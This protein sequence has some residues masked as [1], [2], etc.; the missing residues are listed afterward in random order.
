M[1]S[2]LDRDIE[3]ARALLDVHPRAAPIT[4]L[5]GLPRDVDGAIV[6]VTSHAHVDLTVAL[7]ERGIPVLLEKPL[8]TDD[9]GLDALLE[10][11]QHTGVSLWPAMI[12]RFNPAF[13]AALEDLD[14]VMF[15][16]A[17]RL[18]PYSARALDIDVVLDLMIHDLDLILSL[19]DGEVTDLRAVG[20]PVLTERPDMAHAR[21]EFS[22]GAVAVLA[23]SRVSLAPTR[24]LRLFG[25]R[26]YH[27]VDLL[28]RRVHRCRR[29]PGTESAIEA[30]GLPV[31]EANALREQQGAF[32]THLVDGGG[33]DGGLERAA[34]SLRIAL[35]LS[36]TI[37]E[38]LHRWSG[39]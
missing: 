33:G 2:V 19:V 32:V 1:V 12:E 38:G 15:A 22:S 4:S 37:A 34:R 35:D 14:T 16:Q 39:C 21:L 13:V 36:R 25:P 20:A 8:A 29:T 31:V 30:A 6:A 5:D 9:A 18:A 11:V 7:L 27:S 10:A 24:T 3:R 28:Q 17:E 23:S 26:G